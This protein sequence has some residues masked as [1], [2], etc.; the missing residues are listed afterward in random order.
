MGGFVEQ[1]SDLYGKEYGLRLVSWSST[2]DFEWSKLK[3]A[4]GKN[5]GSWNVIFF[6]TY[7]IATSTKL[8]GQ[9][10]V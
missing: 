5:L 6:N 2:I 4:K 1:I 10:Y 9:K 3:V 8:E 7:Q